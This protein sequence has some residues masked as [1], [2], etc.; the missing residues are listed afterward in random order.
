MIFCK[1]K[2]PYARSLKTLCFLT[3]VAEKS[4]QSQ[5]QVDEIKIEFQCSGNGFAG[6]RIAR[7][8]TEVKAA[9]FLRII[10]GKA[11]KDDDSQNRQRKTQAGA[12]HKDIDDGSD[13][14]APQAHDHKGT[15]G[16]QVSFGG[17]AVNAHSAESCGGN[18]KQAGNAVTGIGQENRRQRNAHNCRKAPEY[19]LN[20]LQRAAVDDPA[21]SKNHQKRRQQKQPAQTGQAGALRG[22]VEKKP[23]QRGVGNQIGGKG[24]QAE[25]RSHVVVNFNHVLAK[26]FVY[27]CGRFG[28]DGGKIF[29]F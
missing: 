13:N 16:G 28:T 1:K 8:G 19:A 7:V 22:N 17:V 11:G 29:I 25:S 9:D 10:C 20:L 5:E 6:K 21:E 23:Y 2:A 3:A 26:P 27:G 24:G 15:H 14:D 12:L 18:Q 4:E